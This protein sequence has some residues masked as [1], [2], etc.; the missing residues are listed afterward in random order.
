VLACRQEG[1]PVPRSSR[2]ASKCTTASCSSPRVRRTSPQAISI[3]A[4]A[5]V[6]SAPVRRSRSMAPSRTRSEMGP[7]EFAASTRTRFARAVDNRIGFASGMRATDLRR[8]A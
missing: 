5:G 4:A 7:V 6:V 8:Q 1:L 2:L 3:R